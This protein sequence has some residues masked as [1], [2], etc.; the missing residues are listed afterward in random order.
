MLCNTVCQ[1]QFEFA[2]T[3]IIHF[4][5]SKKLCIMQSV[6]EEDCCDDVDF[7]RL[8]LV[9]F[10]LASCRAILKLLVEGTEKIPL[11]VKSYVPLQYY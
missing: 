11:S 6:N 8:S 3:L 5:I 4:A 2:F 9:S 10:M 1:I 7:F